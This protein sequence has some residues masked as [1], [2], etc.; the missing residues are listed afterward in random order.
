MID[1]N[2]NLTYEGAPIEVLQQLI[3]QRKEILKQNTRDAVIATSITVLKSLRADT[4][5]APKKA[6]PSSFTISD[7]GWFGGWER[8]G[9]IFHR[10]PRAS[11][12]PKAPKIQG[13]YPVNLAGQHYEKGEIVKVYK[14]EPINDTTMQWDKTKHK[15]CWYVFAKSQAVVEDFAVQHMTRRISTYT[16]LAKLTLGFAM[17]AVSTQ[18]NFASDVQSAKAIKAAS[19]SAQVYKS[20]DIES[21]EYIVS[22]LDVLNY[23]A[24]ALKSGSGAVDKAI[25][26]AANSIAGRLRKVAGAKLTETIQTPFPEVKGS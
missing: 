1:A 5:Q 4:K 8:V 15:G 19:A 13:I 7:T 20:G 10:V 12:S 2:A 6:R 25:M 24:L 21:G 23:S 16:G 14:V 9:G 17:A 22:I 3:E 11:N 18:G 26:K